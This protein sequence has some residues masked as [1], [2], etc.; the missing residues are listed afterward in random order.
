[1]NEFQEIRNIGIVGFGNLG[2]QLSKILFEKSLLHAIFLRELN[3]NR[4]G[5]PKLADRMTTDVSL[6]KNC[7]LLIVCVQD[8]VLNDV[9]RTLPLSCPV[10]YVSGSIALNSLMR[11]KTIGVFYPLQSFSKEREEMDW[12]EIPIFIESEDERYAFQLFQL[13]SQL[14]SQVHFADSELRKKMHLAAV[15]INNFVNHQIYIA[16][17]LAKT[18]HFDIEI[19]HPLLKETVQKA[20]IQG[21][22]G[23]QTGPARRKDAR[24]IQ[25]QVQLLQGNYK[26]IYQIITQSIQKTYEEL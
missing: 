7:D 20:I 23:A 22:F 24:V 17:E 11:K 8:E 5:F 6:M 18:H 13:A 3:P 21:A 19:L 1:M 12:H 15:F 9:I 14:S 16:E 2:V 25:A 10:A 26:K 4:L